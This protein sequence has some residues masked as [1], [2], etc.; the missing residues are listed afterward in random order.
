MPDGWNEKVS[1]M[2][3]R[4]GCALRVYKKMECWKLVCCYIIL[5]I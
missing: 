1:S 3:V 4:E 2:V 5:P